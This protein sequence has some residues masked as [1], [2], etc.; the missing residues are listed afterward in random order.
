[1][2][3]FLADCLKAR[4]ADDA[5]RV[6]TIE[7]DPVE[8]DR[9]YIETDPNIVPIEG[10]SVDPVVID[11]VRGLCLPG[12]VMVTLDSDHTARHVMAE[13]EAYAPLVSS[14]QHLVVQDTRGGGPMGH[15]LG[16]HFQ[17]HGPLGAV[18]AWL[19]LYEAEWEIDFE[20][21]RF[22]GSQHCF[23]WLRRKARA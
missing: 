17:S 10:S 8:I 20:P 2:A 9:R 7:H 5:Y 1:M 18:E 11:R 14:S 12:P 19:D 22:M 23:G 21:E 15:Y 3:A 16:T 13:L 4:H 6:I